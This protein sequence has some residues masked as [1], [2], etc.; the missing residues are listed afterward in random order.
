[1]TLELEQKSLQW[2]KKNIPEIV[3]ADYLSEKDARGI[4][5]RIFKSKDEDTEESSGVLRLFD[6]AE[7]YLHSHAKGIAETY[8]VIIGTVEINGRQYTEGESI[9][10]PVGATHN[11]KCIGEFALVEFNKKLVLPQYWKD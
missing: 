9:L 11:L 5:E 1:M 6:G 2:I 7:I 8:T 4:V 3:D 10:C